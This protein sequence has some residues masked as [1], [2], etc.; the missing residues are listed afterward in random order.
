MAMFEW[1]RHCLPTA[2][3]SNLLN[4]IISLNVHNKSTKVVVLS[5]TKEEIETYRN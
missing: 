4:I 2:V 5:M 3:K 1:K